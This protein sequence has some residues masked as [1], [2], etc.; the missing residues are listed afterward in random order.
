[1]V[2]AFRFNFVCFCVIWG[3]LGSSPSSG[4]W[5]FFRSN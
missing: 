1:V 2:I 3:V 4:T 5:F